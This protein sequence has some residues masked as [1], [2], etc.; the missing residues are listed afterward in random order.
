MKKNTIKLN[1]SQLRNII[2][3]SIKKVLKENIDN[4]ETVTPQYVRFNWNI[5]VPSKY[6]K[7]MYELEN[8]LDSARWVASFERDEEPAEMQH[9]SIYPKKAGKVNEGSTDFLHYE[10]INRYRDEDPSE[11]SD[12]E[13][14][15]RIEYMFAYR[16]ALQGNESVLDR[17]I[18]EAN[19]RGIIN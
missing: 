11:L 3:E 8:Q 19:R 13:L 2:K 18:E 16:W 17:Y 15:N 10:T 14:K 12:G 1:E 9:L 7:K 6:A 5:T 4:P